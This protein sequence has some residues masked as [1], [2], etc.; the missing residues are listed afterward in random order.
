MTGVQTCA[1]PIYQNGYIADYVGNPTA[2]FI[3]E[4]NKQDF[5]PNTFRVSNNLSQKPIVALLPGSRK[6]EIVKMLPVY[7]NIANEFKE[8][9]FVVAAMKAVDNSLY[10]S[11][12]NLHFVYDQTYN[13]LKTAKAAIV[14]SGTATLETA[15]FGVPQI[16]CYRTSF[17]TYLIGSIVLTKI[18]FISLVNIIMDKKV[19][20]EIIQRNMK[21]RIINELHNIL[22][23]EKYYFEMKNNY[24]Q[25]IEKL[26]SGNAPLN[27]AKI[28][29]KQL[30]EQ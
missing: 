6:Q 24:Q 10:K 17:F 16:V 21:Q 13:L 19:V 9:E 1:L 4:Y 2:F 7:A 14:T 20:E 27:A 18:K 12:E 11:F 8:Y 26:N 29:Y 28:I 30:V 3:S 23:N 15:L 25:L 5:E 22:D